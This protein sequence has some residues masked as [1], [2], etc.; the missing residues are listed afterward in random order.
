MADGEHGASSQAGKLI[1]GTSARQKQLG[2]SSSLSHSSVYAQK[3]AASKY[4]VTIRELLKDGGKGKA[5]TRLPTQYSNGS[6]NSLHLRSVLSSY[7]TYPVPTI[8]Q[9]VPPGGS[10]HP[11]I[12]Y[13][14]KS[15]FPSLSD[16]SSQTST[17]LISLLNAMHTVRQSKHTHS[18]MIAPAHDSLPSSSMTSSI[19][20]EKKSSKRHKLIAAYPANLTPQESC[21]RPHCAAKDRLQMW[22]PIR[23]EA[24]SSS[25]PHADIQCIQDVMIYVWARST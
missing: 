20:K 7:A 5:V 13:F 9:M 23:D 11:Q 2:W 6:M 15:T 25:L 12:C 3:A 17:V 8:Q 24:S 16:P 19:G 22:L 1:I 4:L 10:T 21:L 14:P 18:L